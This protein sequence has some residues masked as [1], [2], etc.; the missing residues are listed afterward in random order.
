MTENTP[1]PD[2]ISPGITK[3][4]VCNAPASEFSGGITMEQLIDEMDEMSHLNEF[5]LG[6]IDRN[7][8][9]TTPE[10]Y[11]SQVQPV[12]D[13]LEVEI[14]VRV[15]PGITKNELKLIVQD[16]IDCEIALLH[17]T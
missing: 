16:W 15:Y 2:C 1:P 17:K 13:L 3:E 10:A 8:G 5:I 6:Y 4:Q 9:Y 7:G 12:L 14:R 11:F